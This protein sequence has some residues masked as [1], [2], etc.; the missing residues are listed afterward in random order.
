MS[1]VFNQDSQL[2]QEIAAFLARVTKSSEEARHASE[3]LCTQQ[4]VADESEGRADEIQVED[5]VPAVVDDHD[6]EEIEYVRDEQETEQFK[7]KLQ[8]I[9]NLRPLV[10]AVS[11][12]ATSGSAE[13]KQRSDFSHHQLM[14]GGSLLAVG[15]VCIVCY[16]INAS[17]MYVLLPVVGAIACVI[18]TYKSRQLWETKKE[19]FQRLS[20]DSIPISQN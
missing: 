16:A 11:R 18:R 1:T 4:A 8:G 14:A 10:N 6:N 13:E 2:N 9:N 20:N 12:L 15:M 5:V 3:E 7:A 17:W 19:H